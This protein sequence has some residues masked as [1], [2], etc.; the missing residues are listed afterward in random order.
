MLRSM[1][2]AFGSLVLLQLLTL[3]GLGGLLWHT[4]LRTG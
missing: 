1:R 3:A 4:F 2:G